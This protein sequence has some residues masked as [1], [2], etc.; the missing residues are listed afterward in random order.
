MPALSRSTFGFRFPPAGLSLGW[1]FGGL[2]RSLHGSSVVNGVPPS[3][4][5]F[6][7]SSRRVVCFSLAEVVAWQ[8]AKEAVYATHQKFRSAFLESP[9]A[10]IFEGALQFGLGI[11]NDWPI[12]W[13]RLT[14]RTARDEDKTRRAACGACGHCLSARKHAGGT[15]ST[16]QSRFLPRYAR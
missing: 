13:H 15:S 2:G 5:P 10:E 16:G 12:T 6:S 8:E 9:G 4:R 3:D 14:Q 11:H 1:F 7:I